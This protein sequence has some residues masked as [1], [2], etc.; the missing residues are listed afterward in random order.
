M[1]QG[2]QRSPA[3]NN[4]QKPKALEGEQFAPEHTLGMV[5]SGTMEL[6]NGQKRVL[7][8][9]GEL[10]FVKKDCLVKYFKYS[11]KDEA[12]EKISISFNEDLLRD[13]CLKNNYESAKDRSIFSFTKLPKDN[14]LRSFMKSLQNYHG[15]SADEN[16]KKVLFLKQQ[17]ALWLL[18]KQDESFKNILF[19]F[20]RSY[21]IDLK[22]FMQKNFRFNISVE[23]FAYLTGRSVATFKRDFQ[24]T[25]DSPPRKWLQKRRLSEAH[26]LISEKEQ[27]PSNIYLELGFENLSHFSTAFRRQFHY[28]PNA[29]KSK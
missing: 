18:L 28:A 4:S 8:K 14:L 27:S 15:N 6:Y 29:L 1:M 9:K 13:F 25:F 20:S 7:F 11:D 2:K 17:E 10:Y 19:D 24:R 12:V 21:K 5:T 16:V 26:Y 23:K 22:S 3:L